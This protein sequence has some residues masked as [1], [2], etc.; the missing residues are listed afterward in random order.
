MRSIFAGIAAAWFGLHALT[1]MPP[2]VYANEGAS[3]G[4]DGEPIYLAIMWTARILFAGFA[5]L[6]LAAVD[7][8]WIVG[9]DRE[10]RGDG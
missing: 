4:L 7:W 2:G 3:N 10:L 9:K 6:A 5:F 1:F 8:A